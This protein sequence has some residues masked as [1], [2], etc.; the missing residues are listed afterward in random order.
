MSAVQKVNPVNG[1]SSEAPLSFVIIG[2][3]FGGIG[4]GVELK[5]RGIN[6]FLIL[7]KAEDV[8]GCWRQNT[9]PGAACD[10]RPTSIPSPSS[11]TPTGRMP[12]PGSRR[13]TAISGIAHASSGC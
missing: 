4:M 8:G 9:Y 1:Y 3:G 2:A 5:R 12:S 11:P 10:V 7:E 13:S 6:D